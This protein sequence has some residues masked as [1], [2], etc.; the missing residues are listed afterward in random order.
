MRKLSILIAI[1]VTCGC[2]GTQSDVGSQTNDE[3]GSTQLPFDSSTSVPDGY[4]LRVDRQGSLRWNGSPINDEQLVEYLAKWAE[5]TP[6]AGR[7]L[8]AFQ[9]GVAEKRA[10]WVRDRVSQSGLCE[11]KRCAEVGWDVKQP[12][13]Y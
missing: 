6:D 9:S 5:L 2:D 3:A 11:Q 8:V 10:S 1:F 7:L 13:V 4:L 12:V